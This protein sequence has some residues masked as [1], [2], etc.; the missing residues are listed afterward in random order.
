[1]DPEVWR[2][3]WLVAGVVLLVGEMSTAGLFLLPFSIGA[4]AAAVLAFLGI[5]FTWQIIVCFVISAAAFAA[6]RP[7]A[8]R[9]DRTGKT[10]GIGS[11]RLVNEPGVVLATIPPHGALGL[12]R[13]GRE[14]WRAESV[15]GR[16]IEG[17]ARVRIIDV[18]GTRVLVAPFEAPVPDGPLPD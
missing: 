10:D 18:R 4:F 17:G 1:M 11:R 13:V 2:W 16:T 5:A 8:H 6:L 3:V 12:I 9:L 7:L 14:E 15:D